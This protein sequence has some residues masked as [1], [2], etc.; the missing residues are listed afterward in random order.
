MKRTFAVVAL[1]LVLRALQVFGQ[2]VDLQREVE[3]LRRRVEQLERSLRDEQEA[4]PPAWQAGYDRGFYI[5]SPD[6]DYRVTI[7]S[8][9]QADGRFGLGGY[10]R[11]RDH[12]LLRHIRSS[13][14]GWVAE[15]YE[16]R[17]EY[18]FGKDAVE[19][20]DGYINILAARE[21]EFRAG[22]FRAPFSVEELAPITSYRLVEKSV[23]CYLVPGYKVGTMVHGKWEP[24]SYSLGMFEGEKGDGNFLSAGRLVLS[25]AVRPGRPT[26]SLGINAAE[27]HGTRV[28]YNGREFRTDLQTAYLQYAPGVVFS[29]RK[30][31]LGGD[32]SC[33][34]T[35]IGLVGEFV[36]SE[37]DLRKGL[38]RGSMRNEGWYVQLS[39]VVTGENATALGVVPRH[40]FNPVRGYWGAFEI[41][42]RFAQLHV[43]KDILRM[44]FANKGSTH[45]AEVI[46]GG[47]NWY[48]NRHMKIM[49]DYVQSTFHNKLAYGSNSDQGIIVRFQ[50]GF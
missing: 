29:G 18:D 3:D 17:I 14:E 13:I 21:L 6:G 20:K 49:V 44:G 24:L 30:V 35:P 28:S 19:L 25:T 32:L 43:D 34:G 47:A 46:T 9:I 2:D 15:S 8:T 33:W 22:Q 1:A 50:L 37:E 7:N 42:A 38:A 11:Q 12:L 23:V 26:V 39:G 36:T 16:F 48:L 41:A 40:D 45:E 31:L 4:R 5:E 27:D 10:P